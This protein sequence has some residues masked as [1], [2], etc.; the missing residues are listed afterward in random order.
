[1]ASSHPKREYLPI[2]ENMTPENVICFCIFIPDDVEHIA[3]FWGALDA[4]TQRY[5]W[6][7][8]LTAD[9][10]TVADYWREIIAENRVNFE[11][12]Y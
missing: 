5:S 11:G 8:P 3:I 9:S 12:S 10:E 7:K 6:G 1:M 2:P 4:L